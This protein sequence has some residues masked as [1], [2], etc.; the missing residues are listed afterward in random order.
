MTMAP[1]L[2]APVC[3]VGVIAAGLIVW[4][5][6]MRRSAGA[7]LRNVTVSRAWLTHHHSEDRS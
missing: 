2:I 1:L 5:V 3:L 6:T 4:R 7:S